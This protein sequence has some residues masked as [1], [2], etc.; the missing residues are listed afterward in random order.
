MLYGRPEN[1]TVKPNKTDRLFFAHVQKSIVHSV[2]AEPLVPN[3]RATAMELNSSGSDQVTK[4]NHMAMSILDGQV[5]CRQT[6]QKKL[7]RTPVPA[8][9]AFRWCI[10]MAKWSTRSARC[11]RET[12][13]KFSKR[14]TRWTPKRYWTTMA[15]RIWRPLITQPET[16]KSYHAKAAG[17]T[18]APCSP[19]PL[20]W[21][22][23][24]LCSALI[25]FSIFHLIWRNCFS[26]IW[27]AI[28]I[29]TQHCRWLCSALAAWSETICMGSC[30]I[31]GDVAHHSLSIYSWRSLRAHSAR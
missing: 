6:N 2:D 12:I 30:R 24:D 20:L 15:I 25:L 8:C 18:I 26:G 19:T 27:C 10:A 29:S 13:R 1:V 7:K 9:L 17:Y 28:K 22:Y 21:R 4:V 16:M 31:T 5:I 11:I 3:S 23:F 14:C